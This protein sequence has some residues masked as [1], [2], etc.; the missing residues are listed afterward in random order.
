MN[1]KQV[2]L[3][4]NSKIP[5][6]VKKDYKKRFYSEYN[7]NPREVNYDE[8]VVQTAIKMFMEKFPP[9]NYKKTQKEI[10]EIERKRKENKSKEP[11]ISIE[12]SQITR[13]ILLRMAKVIEK[14]DLFS[15]MATELFRLIDTF[16]ND[17]YKPLNQIGPLKLDIYNSS[18]DLLKECI[19]EVIKNHGADCEIKEKGALIK[20]NP[21]GSKVG[22]SLLREVLREFQDPNL[23]LNKL[24][25]EKKS[26]NNQ[27]DPNRNER[28][29]ATLEARAKRA[30]VGFNP[31][32]NLVYNFTNQELYRQR[33][34]IST[35]RNYM[36]MSILEKRIDLENQE[37]LGKAALFYTNEFRKKHKRGKL[38]WEPTIFYIGKK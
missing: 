13:D 17:P 37:K 26:R 33:N 30:V 29:S 11:D 19:L 18:M 7:L 35:R 34:Y 32:P 12:K 6:F 31:P 38:Q 4:V 23:D 28:V 10:E 25:T 1:Q 15:R 9:E 36:D 22:L 3:F 27:I 20:F 14:K 2:Y 24:K 5:A 16:L 8:E 21:N